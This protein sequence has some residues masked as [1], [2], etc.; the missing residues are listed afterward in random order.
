MEVPLKMGGLYCR[1]VI[2]IRVPL[3]VSGTGG[4]RQSLSVMDFVVAA[5]RSIKQVSIGGK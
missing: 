1:D 3:S 5:G 4:E 2:K